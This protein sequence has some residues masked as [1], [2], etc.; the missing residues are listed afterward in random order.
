MAT[1]KKKTTKKV[2][3]P[4]KTKATSTKSSKVTARRVC[5]HIPQ[6]RV[7]ACV[8]KRPGLYACVG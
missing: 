4:F 8:Q 2:K 1:A 6:S 3:D 5:F 7:F